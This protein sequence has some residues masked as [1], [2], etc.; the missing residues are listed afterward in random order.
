MI[1]KAYSV[2]DRKTLVYSPPF[3]APT[4]GAAMRIISDAAGDVNSQ[5]GRHPMDYV[6][7]YVGDFDD[8]KGILLAVTPL[9]HVVDVVSLVQVQPS[10]PLVAPP[11]K[12][13]PVVDPLKRSPRKGRR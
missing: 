7:F 13:G 4:D 11:S 3:Y 9:M 6:L 10:L 2:Y 1:T 5:L 8:L 12:S